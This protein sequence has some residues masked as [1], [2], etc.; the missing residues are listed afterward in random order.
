MANGPNCREGSQITS[1]F[2]SEDSPDGLLALIGIARKC[3]HR[4]TPCLS[5][6]FSRTLRGQPYSSQESARV[7]IF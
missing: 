3:L 2:S 4:I 1:S 6:K 5:S 7:S